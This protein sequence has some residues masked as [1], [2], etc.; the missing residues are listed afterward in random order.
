MLSHA[1][2]RAISCAGGLVG[3][4]RAARL[5]VVRPW[6]IRPENTTWTRQLAINSSLA[7]DVDPTAIA[8]PKRSPHSKLLRVCS[9]RN[10]NAHFAAIEGEC[11]WRRRLDVPFMLCHFY[12]LL[13]PHIDEH[14]N[15]CLTNSPDPTSRNAETRLAKVH[16]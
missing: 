1:G 13:T 6:R 16:G 5:S 11:R 14:C 15:L 8:P 10:A 12:I 4:R 7:V 9:D 3:R 2:E